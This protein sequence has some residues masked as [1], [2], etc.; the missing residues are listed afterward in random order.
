M[1]NCRIKVARLQ[2]SK[3]TRLQGCIVATLLLS[4][5]FFQP[6]F[7][8]AEVGYAMRG[9][10][11][12]FNNWDGAFNSSA[13]DSDGDNGFIFNSD[14]FSLRP[15]LSVSGGYD[16]NVYLAPANQI[17]DTYYTISPGIMLVYGSENDD[18]ISLNYVYEVTKYS[19]EDSL[20]YD[21]HLFSL[22]LHLA[23]GKLRIHLSDQ[24]E[25][26][27]DVDPETSQ[28]T[29]RLQNIENLNISRFISRKTSLLASQAYIINDYED[30]GFLDYDEFWLGGSVHHQTFPKVSTFVGGRYG[31]INMKDS[32]VIGDSDYV[33]ADVGIQGRLTAKST[34]H[35]QLGWQNRRFKDDIE[36][37]NEWTGVIGL[38]SRFSSRTYWGVDASRG[39]TPSSQRGGYTRLPASITPTI[40]HILWR[41]H[42][43][44]SLS[45]SYEIADYYG[46][47]GKEDRSDKYWYIT[48]ILDWSPVSAF[49]VGIGY[50]YSKQES[51][52]DEFEYEQNLIFLRGMGNY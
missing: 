44:L 48:G 29:A 50:T 24:F 15:H 31:I 47:Q 52:F 16:D 43:A 35:T 12:P 37:I 46:P 9:D 1:I 26:S 3:V 32:N 8:Q 17:D 36:D 25:N 27:T 33:E 7:V 13:S 14:S 49:N 2:G 5:L 23:P 21:S 22:G 38:S 28:H 11:Q 41:D 45:G 42:I 39:L 19:T 40:R 10:A 6:S 30:D 4:F 34:L 18:Y 51:N 20:D